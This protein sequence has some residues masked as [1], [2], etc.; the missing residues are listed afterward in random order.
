M[1]MF[2]GTLVT[3]IDREA[4]AV[5][6]GTLESLAVTVKELT[7]PGPVGFPEMAPVLLFKLRPAG[8]EP[9]VIDQVTGAVPPDEANVS[10]AYGLPTC[11]PGNEV[12]VTLSSAAT[13][14]DSATV[15]VRCLGKLSSVAFTVKLAWP[16]DVGLP[17]IV[18]AVGSR[19]SPLGSAPEAMAQVTGAVPPDE[20]N[21]VPG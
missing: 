15:A 6:D 9:E 12:V 11:T 16:A 7:S 2:K 20:V 17:V 5:S 4:V 10:P 19:L 18:P 8:S 14:I 1:V 3:A 21:V 13:L